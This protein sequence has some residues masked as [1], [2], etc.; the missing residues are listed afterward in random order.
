M[1]RLVAPGLETLSAELMQPLWSPPHEEPIVF[2][3][4]RGGLR[5]RSVVH[6]LRSVGCARATLLDGGWKA[7]RAE[8]SSELDGWRA[9]PVVGCAPGA[10][11]LRGAPPSLGVRI[12]PSVPQT[13]TSS[14][15]ARSREDL[16]MRG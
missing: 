15:T 5:S 1:S 14:A 13:A 9:P 3:C 2:H 10:K 7:Y 11:D 12:Q 6:F 8:V 4:W 16:F